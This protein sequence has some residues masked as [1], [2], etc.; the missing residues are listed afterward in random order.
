MPDTHPGMGAIPFEG[1]TAFRVWAPFATAVSVVGAFNAWN[2]EADPLA[3]EGGGI[4]SGEVGGARLGQPYK[5]ALRSPYR[6]GVFL[7]NDPYARCMTQS[8]G[9]SLIAEIDVPER[10]EHYTTPAWNELVI[11]ELH[12]GSFNG[13]PAGP[14]GR[15]TFA[16]VIEKLDY[17]RD[18]GFNAV[19]ILPVDEFPGDI[20]MGYNPS[21]IFAIE[22]AYGGPKGLCALVD[23][24]HARGLAMIFDIVYNHL[25]PSD[26]DL[27]QFDGWGEDGGGGIYFYNDARR[28]KTP[29]GDTRPDYGRGEVRQFLRDNAL[30]WLEAFRFDGLRWD[31]TAYIRRTGGPFGDDIPAGWS[32][33]QWIRNEIDARQPWKITIAED[34]QDDAWITKPT[35]EGGAGF[36][37]QWGAQL[38]HALR[39]TMAAPSDYARDMG[40][41]AGLIGQRYNGRAFQRVNYTESHDEVSNDLRL[42]ELIWPGNADSAPS[43]KRSTLGAA[44]AF[45]APGIPMIFMGQEFLAWGKWSDSVMMDWSNAERFTGITSLYR[46]LAQ[47]RRSWHGTTEGLKGEGVN[48]FHV[49]DVDKLVAFHR[50]SFGGPRDDVVVVANCGGR[51]FD[52]YAIGL[53]RAG[54]WRCRFNSDWRGYSPAFADHPSF[55]VESNG[56]GRDGMPAAGS[57]S[58]GAYTA[59][60]FSQDD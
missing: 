51:A 17:I 26:L 5:F 6:D 16:S 31:M 59:L 11:Y 38:M 50:W 25:G 58:I 37:A 12:V 41:L 32:L 36:S 13:D 4:W 20:S 48:V 34:M 55:D 15:G 29:W 46:D 57:L 22:H 39:A 27:W 56:G 2:A 7:K 52:A 44:L 1:G 28:R 40:A 14:S 54:P 18:L 3:S 47:L 35:S 42:P 43:Q 30:H 19:H 24:A 49:N 8:N 10:V 33:M 23:A 60:I 53:P 21:A 9:D 45:T